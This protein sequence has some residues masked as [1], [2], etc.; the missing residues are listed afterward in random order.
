MVKKAP[1]A[2][3]FTPYVPTHLCRF[4][5]MEK[6]FHYILLILQVLCW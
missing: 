4:G 1:G 5:L 2:L 6:P 3:H